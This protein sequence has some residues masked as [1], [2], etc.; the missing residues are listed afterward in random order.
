MA[1]LQSTLRISVL[2]QTTAR[3]RGISAALNSLQARN[4]MMMAPFTGMVGRIAAFGGAYLGVTRACAARSAR[5]WTS[6]RP[7]P[8]C[9]R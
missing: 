9:A 7:S 5:Q 8:T 1:V 3:L 6:N 2:D 4:R